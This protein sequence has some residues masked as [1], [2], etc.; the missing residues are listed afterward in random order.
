M[1]TITKKH[2]IKLSAIIALTAFLT[3]FFYV[4]ESLPRA[5]R[6]ATAL[7]ETPVTI[8]SGLSHYLN[9][10]IPVYETPWAILLINLVFSVIVVL[11]VDKLIENRKSKRTKCD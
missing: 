5:I 3:W 7:I 1:M 6:A 4:H 8:A 2:I 11:L 9:L 10:G